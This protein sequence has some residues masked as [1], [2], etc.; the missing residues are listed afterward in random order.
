MTSS[1]SQFFWLIAA[2]GTQLAFVFLQVKL[3][4]SL[5]AAQQLGLFFVLQAIAGAVGL[6][7]VGPV[8]NWFNRELHSA[9][10]HRTALFFLEK[11][12]ISVSLISAMVAAVGFGLGSVL[13]DET[14]LA[15]LA[16]PAFVFVL[17]TS[18][19]NT[20]VPAFNLLGRN[21][22][23]AVLV[24]L[25][26]LISLGLASELHSLL[27]QAPSA[28]LWAL[29]LGLPML[30]VGLFAALTL[31]LK[32][33]SDL[34]ATHIGTSKSPS[35]S[36]SL[37]FPLIKLFRFALPLALVNG[38]LWI[39]TQS[40]RPLTE[41]YL[42]ASV[43]VSL[44]LGLG[45]T[46]SIFAAAET[47]VQQLVLPRFYKQISQ[48]DPNS[49]LVASTETEW[50]RVWRFTL[51]IY[52][53]GA[54]ALFG[55]GRSVIEVL[56][57]NY[58]T[59][60]VLNA[61]RVGCVIEL[62]RMLNNVAALY[63]HAHRSTHQLI[64]PYLS[65][66]LMTLA[67]MSLFLYFRTPERIPFALLIGQIALLIWLAGQPLF[68]SIS[69]DGKPILIWGAQGVVV[70]GI[71]LLFPTFLPSLL[72]LGLAGLIWAWIAAF[73]LRRLHGQS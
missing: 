21:K 18:L 49:E 38:A 52:L 46:A 25:S 30:C 50:L 45:L 14:N 8:G 44:G 2:R 43:L 22:T 71:A 65:V 26:S 7:L 48:P 69:S 63:H 41:A 60:E 33:G 5:L 12:V 42:G 56:A 1:G 27:G 68:K 4:T 31:F 62:F 67:L 57:P 39:L 51:P 59:D 24:I 58:S 37:S 9:N 19:L 72:S 29:G 32:S 6:S 3:M 15:A 53:S 20:F 17:G 23:F 13:R 64:K 40:Y 66:A 61:F 34:E 55:M 70:A 16:L 36:E 28:E 54:I 73:L 47:F 11:I 10:Q 35:T